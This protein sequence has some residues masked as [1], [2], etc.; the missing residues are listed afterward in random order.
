MENRKKVEEIIERE[1]FFLFVLQN[2]LKNKPS[3]LFF[4]TCRL[5][6]VLFMFA[7]LKGGTSKQ[8]P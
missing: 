7:F 1:T 8:T 3:F 5:S 6:T 2:S 4:F